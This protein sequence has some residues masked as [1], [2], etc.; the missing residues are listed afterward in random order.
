MHHKNQPIKCRWID[1]EG[2][3]QTRHFHS[4]RS[5]VDRIGISVHYFKKLLKGLSIKDNSLKL[6][7]FPSEEI[8]ID[9]HC[10]LCKDV[11]E[12]SQF[13]HLKSQKHR[14]N[15]ASFYAWLS[16][17]KGRDDPIGDLARD[18]AYDAEMKGCNSIKKWKDHIYSIGCSGACNALDEAIIEFKDQR[19]TQK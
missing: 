6:E 9:D 17:Q 4:V 5:A 18:A 14:E 15:Y 13:S 11:R 19:I 8:D 1:R 3:Q 7:V 2:K 16:N 12:G 10:P